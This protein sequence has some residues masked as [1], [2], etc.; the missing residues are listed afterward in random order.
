[1]TIAL[2][3]GSPTIDLSSHQ[4]W[5]VIGDDERR[6]VA[7][8]LDRNV[9]S[10]AT[11]PESAALERELESYV[12]VKHA[13][14]THS[15]TSALH[16]ACA[17]AGIGAGDHVLVPAYSFVATP[18]SVLHCGAIP[19]FVDVDEATGLMDPVA[20][21]AAV[22][23]RT[24]AIMPVHVHG[25]A[26]DMG[27]LLALAEKHRLILVED[28]AQAHGATWNGKPV[29]TMGRAGA[30]SFQ[31]SKNLGIGEGGA[32]L[33][34]D[35][36]LAEEANRLRTFGQDV[37]LA[38]RDSFDLERPLDGTR[39][40]QSGRIGWMYRGNE[41]SAAIARA[42][43]AKLPART[44]LCQENAE[45][46]TKTLATLPGVLPPTVP[47]GSTSVHHKFRVRFDPTA[48][49]VKLSPRALRDAMIRALRAEGLEV[50]LWQNAPLSAQ[51]VFQ[52]LEGFGGGWPWS[53]DRE[54]DYRALY[55]P[56]RFPRT[57]ALLDGSLILFSQSR[58]LIGQS[59]E[60]VDKYAE[61][62]TR[63]W[64]QR[65]E[66]AARAGNATA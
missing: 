40:L 20:A 38:E 22:T 26:A 6:A 55:A 3:G 9:L 54:T 27:P 14:L 13:L 30:F 57:Q 52:R 43:I 63:V 47:R 15:G 51:P 8:V 42:A 66:I 5:P 58:P 59:R 2:F 12:G 32:V 46:L 1:V 45:R 41:L 7:R 23:P 49:G 36:A 10:G 19:I 18:L 33:T 64:N 31:S 44:K 21:A 11:A 61:A 53:A 34:N 50:V 4:L 29:G 24:R 28:A 25:C 56:S 17:A 48:A 60:T 16:L 39:A 65:A 35:D 37:T 62:F